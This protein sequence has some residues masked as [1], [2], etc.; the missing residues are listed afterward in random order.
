[1]NSRARL[2]LALF[3]A[4]LAGAFV[5]GRH[6]LSSLSYVW[7]GLFFSALI[8]SRL[9]MRGLKLERSGPARA[10]VGHVMVERFILRNESQLPKLLVEVRD[11]T[12]LPGYRASF[13]TVLGLFE[14]FDLVGHSGSAVHVGIRA[15]EELSWKVR[16]VCTQRGWF[17]MGPTVIRSSD[18]F[19]LFPREM[20]IPERQHL[21]VL[22]GMIPIRTFPLPAG[23]LPGGEALHR[24]THQVTPNASGVRDYAPGDSFNRIHW[25]STARKDRLIVKEFEFDPLADV[26]IV[27]DGLRR[28]QF[29]LPAP[30]PDTSGNGKRPPADGLEIAR[31]LPP[32]TEEYTVSI[33]ASL[34]FHLVQRDIDVG[35]MGYG[36]ARHVIQPDR[37]HAQLQRILESL[38]VFDAIGSRNLRDVI[39]IESEMMQRGATVVFVAADVSPLLSE[40]ATELIRKGRSVIAILLDSATFGGPQAAKANQAE[41]KSAGALVRTVSMG[42]DLELALS[43][44]WDSRLAGLPRLA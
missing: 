1:M 35:V 8:W 20:E 33:A 34:S 36:G 37:G 41:L 25:R 27:L 21:V 24:R 38:A 31:R 13:L 42:E 4:S 39:R 32:I 16:T 9:S 40:A 18:P 22:P 19:G 26:W 5:T 3:L 11:L 44:R 30:P 6:L 12:E 29:E 2:V 43:Q 17:A 10:Q 14:R 28:A 7:G 23:L 15:Q